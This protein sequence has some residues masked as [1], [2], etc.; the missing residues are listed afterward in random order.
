MN[1]FNS[2]NT[3]PTYLRQCRWSSTNGERC[4]RWFCIRTYQDLT[5]G[6]MYY[7]REEQGA[8]SRLIF[9]TS[10]EYDCCALQA[11]GSYRG[12]YR[13]FRHATNGDSGVDLPC[14]GV[15]QCR[16]CT[17]EGVCG[18]WSNSKT[19]NL[20][21]MCLATGLK[22]R[23]ISDSWTTNDLLSRAAGQGYHAAGL[24][25]A[26]EEQFHPHVTAAHGLP[27]AAY[28]YFCCISRLI[29]SAHNASSIRRAGGGR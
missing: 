10:I 29:F 21:H 4:D 15:Y 26:G 16:R 9:G 28:M 5:L 14:G 22:S 20:K 25:W 13:L 1:I 23:A 24:P 12:S 6:H 8:R 27:D 18:K 7:H 19:H 17:S 3:L 11:D 2:L